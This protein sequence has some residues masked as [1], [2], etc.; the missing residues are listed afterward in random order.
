[1]L[2][3]GQTWAVAATIKCANQTSTSFPHLPPLTAKQ[4]VGAPDSVQLGEP[5]AALVGKRFMSRQSA[6]A[7][8]GL[9]R[10]GYRYGD[11]CNGLPHRTSGSD[12]TSNGRTL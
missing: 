5:L 7:Q 4:E 3:P 2:S 1:M 8:Y 10:S 9:G 12:W 11:Y 6:A